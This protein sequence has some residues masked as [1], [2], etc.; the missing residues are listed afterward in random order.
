MPPDRYEEMA[1][2]NYWDALFELRDK[3]R[4]E[5]RGGIQ[6]IKGARLPVEVN[7]QGLMRWYQHPEINDTVLS[8]LL[9]F[10]Q[11]IPPGSR[12]GRMKFGGNQVIYILEGKGYTLIDGVR[13]DWAAGDVLNL[14]MKTQGIVVQHFNA[15]TERRARFVAVEPN[16]FAAAGVDR[17][18]GFE[19]LESAPEHARTK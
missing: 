13:H 12:S 1:K 9:V 14:P 7:R 5:K 17:G 10:Q 18:C 19:Q 16:L 4:A 3:Q 11:E 15:D 8:T 6:V 2:T